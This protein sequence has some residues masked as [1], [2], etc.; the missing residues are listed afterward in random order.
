MNKKKK[1]N[2]NVL[3]F[4]AQ[5]LIKNEKDNTLVRK[6]D[7]SIFRLADYG[8][9]RHLEKTINSVLENYY[10]HGQLDTKDRD[11]NSRRFRAGEMFERLSHRAGMNQRI[12]TRLAEVMISGNN[13]DFLDETIDFHSDLHLVLKE[14][15][16]EWR[17]VWQVIVE[18][19]PAGKQM[20][21]FREGLDILIVY[22]DL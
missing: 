17:I 13:A 20:D 8:K 14:L 15:K 1:K 4:G 11:I 6:V 10:Y 22:F 18:N 19:K 5:K 9:D 12:T 3:D 7:G 21:K 16:N 2:K